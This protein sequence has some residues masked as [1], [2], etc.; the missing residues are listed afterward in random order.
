VKLIGKRSLSCQASHYESSY[1]LHDPTLDHGNFL[2]IV[3]LLKKYDVIIY[4]HIDNIIKSA[5]VKAAHHRFKKIKGRG[6]SLTFISKTTVNLIARR[7]YEKINFFRSTR[8]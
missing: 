7:S 3:L 2:D 6:S 1:S 5:Q 8:S 4:E